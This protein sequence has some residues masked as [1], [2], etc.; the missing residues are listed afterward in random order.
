MGSL[1]DQLL[2][3]GFNTGKTQ[4]ERP[5]IIKKEKTKAQGHQEQRNFCEVCELIQPDVERYKHRNPTI[6]AEWICLRCADKNEIDDKFRVTDQS[7]VNKKG[8]FR[9]EHGI[10]C[11]IDPITRRAIDPSLNKTHGNKG[12]RANSQGQRRGQHNKNSGRRDGN[13]GGG[14]Y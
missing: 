4:N 5:K 14:N 13:R 3:A 2:K 8:F 12:A 9:R 10:T 11:K 1:K 6:D 7:D